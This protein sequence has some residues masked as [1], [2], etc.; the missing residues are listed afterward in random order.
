MAEFAVMP[1][2]ESIGKTVQQLN[3]R[4]T[5]GLS[6]VGIKRED[7]ILQENLLTESVKAGDVLLVMG[8]WQKSLR[9]KIR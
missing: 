8:V 1:E 4:S 9:L 5:Y 7:R 6:V 3:F 2:T